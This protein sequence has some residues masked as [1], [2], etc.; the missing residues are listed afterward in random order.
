MKGVPG[1][2]LSAHRQGVLRDAPTLVSAES[3]RTFWTALSGQ[4]SILKRVVYRLPS[5]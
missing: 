1:Y 5:G 4:T 3:Y 2:L